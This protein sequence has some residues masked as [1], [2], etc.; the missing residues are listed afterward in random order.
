[1]SSLRDVVPFTLILDAFALERELTMS[2]NRTPTSKSEFARLQSLR[3]T[4][5][6]KGFQPDTMK[7]LRLPWIIA[8]ILLPAVH[9]IHASSLAPLSPVEQ[10]QIS[11]AAFRGT[12]I[13]LQP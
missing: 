12:V 5:V 4:P 3:D 13:N 2:C 1:H 7:T 11:A 6:Q 9:Q 8:L 10:L